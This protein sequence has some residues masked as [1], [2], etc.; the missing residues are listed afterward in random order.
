[1][2]YC[3]IKDA[4]HYVP[5][6]E[7]LGASKHAAHDMLPLVGMTGAV[8][9]VVTIPKPLSGAVLAPR[10][11]CITRHRRRGQ[12]M[13]LQPD[14]PAERRARKRSDIIQAALACFAR[15]G[16]NNT[17]MDDIVAESGLSKG[18]LYWYFASKDDLFAAALLSVFASFGQEAVA[19]LEQCP[20][21]SDK[22]RAMAQEVVSFCR[23][24]EGLFNLFLEFWASSARREET[25]QLWVG[26][27]NQYK[28][29]VV[30]IIEEGVRSGE[31]KPVDAQQLVW[32]MMAA[33][34]GLSAYVIMVP[35]MDLGLV[36]QVFIETLLKGLGAD[37]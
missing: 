2:I 5:V 33:Y 26:L 16:Y 12:P 7:R 3:E 21:A 32:A 19:A 29:V 31:F 6:A 4:V 23:A 10:M 1:L 9:F 35:D 17:T 36:S 11:L 24:T 34:D 18:S 30:H 28:D 27:L 13:P 14:V 20:T 15:K 8:N 37:G 22:L 25:S